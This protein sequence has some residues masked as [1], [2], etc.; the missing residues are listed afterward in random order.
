MFHASP[1]LELVIQ[2]NIF[3]HWAGN[4]YHLVLVASFL[5]QL[6]PI[7]FSRILP[8]PRNKIKNNRRK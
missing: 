7:F 3:I 2:E 4:S 6:I 5:K 1:N 8:Y